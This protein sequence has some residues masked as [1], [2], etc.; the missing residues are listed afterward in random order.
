MRNTEKIN[1]DSNQIFFELDSLTDDKEL[2][3]SAAECLKV[4][5]KAAEK[6][7]KKTFRPC[8]TALSEVSTSVLE[9]RLQSGKNVEGIGTQRNI[10]NAIIFNFR[11]IEGS[12]L[13]SD[14][15]AVRKRVDRMVADRVKNLFSN[16]EEIITWNSGNFWYPPKGY[17]GWH[18]NQGLPGWRL[19]INYAEEPGKSFFRYRDPETGEIVTAWDKEWNFRLF[20]VTKEKFF[21]HAVYSD[22]NRFSLGY[23]VSTKSGMKPLYKRKYLSG[24]EECDGEECLEGYRWL[25]RNYPSEYANRWHRF[26]AHSTRNRLVWGLIKE[27]EKRQIVHKAKKLVGLAS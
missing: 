1:F 25:E 17:M 27:I 16:S 22:T 9:Q 26:R 20:R 21:W 7:L 14:L 23:L 12:I 8:P 4:Q 5:K 24:Y 15:V 18:T 11:T 3:K 6:F 19:Y 13:R 2:I 10:T